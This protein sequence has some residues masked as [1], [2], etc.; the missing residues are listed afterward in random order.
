MPRDFICYFIFIDEL[1]WMDTKGSELF[2]EQQK[3]VRFYEEL[4][5]SQSLSALELYEAAVEH[6]IDNKIYS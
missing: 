4:S 1:S 2:N 3:Y 5:N 6:F